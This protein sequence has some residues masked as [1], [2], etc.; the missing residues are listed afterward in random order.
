MPPKKK[1]STKQLKALKEAR[2]KRSKLAEKC[3][4]QGKVA[5][6]N[7]KCRNPASKKAS[8]KKTTTKKAPAKKTTTSCKKTVRSVIEA[9][10]NRANV[11]HG[12]KISVTTA[13]GKT[14]HFMV[15]ASNVDVNSKKVGTK[16]VVKINKR[17][18]K[19]SMSEVDIKKQTQCAASGVKSTPKVRTATKKPA[20]KKPAT[21]KTATKKTATK[22]PA[23]KKKASTKQLEA[24]K[25][26]REKRSKLAEKCKKQGKVAGKNGRCRKAKT[27]K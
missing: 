13:S 9:S 17:D 18:G 22:K 25:E 3:K 26:A 11:K 23:T 24:L 6:K 7:G 14:H 10:M 19:V 4:K 27:K 15:I 2:E 8:T 16:R 20:T 5:G 12:D 21:K 1:A